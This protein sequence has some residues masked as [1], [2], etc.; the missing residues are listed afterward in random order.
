MLTRYFAPPCSACQ[1][2]A[3]FFVS[4]VLCIEALLRIAPMQQNLVCIRGL[5]SGKPPISSRLRTPRSATRNTPKRLPSGTK[6]RSEN[7]APAPGST[8]SA[9]TGVRCNLDATFTKGL[10]TTVVSSNTGS[11]GSSVKSMPLPELASTPYCDFAA[12]INSNAK[13]NKGVR[14]SAIGDYRT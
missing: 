10:S 11:G 6:Q 13:E 14:S 4:N 2:A 7:V 12:E 5:V 1:P 3:S 8:R 9:P